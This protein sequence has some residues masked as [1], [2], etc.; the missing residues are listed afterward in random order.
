MLQS[1]N[2][3]Q[4]FLGQAGDTNCLQN[5][6]RCVC[7]QERGE[8]QYN[9]GAETHNLIATKKPRLPVQWLEGSWCWEGGLPTFY[10][11]S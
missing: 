9:L 2:C 3:V 1:Q 5:I 11:H 8:F 7:M 4:I 6:D 10:M